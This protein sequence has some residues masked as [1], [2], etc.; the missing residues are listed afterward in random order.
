MQVYACGYKLSGEYTEFNIGKESELKGIKNSLVLVLIN[1]NANDKLL[2]YYSGIKTIIRN[3][4]KLVIVLDS[5]N[6]ST[7]RKTLCMLAVSMG[8]YNIYDCSMSDLTEDYVKS[9]L[10]RDASELEVEE[11]IGEDISA[12]DKAAELII[13]MQNY[14]RRGDGNALADLVTENKEVILSIPVVMDFL[15]KVYDTHVYGTDIKIS[16]MQQSL[17]VAMK[18]LEDTKTKSKEHMIKVKAQEEELNNLKIESE[19]IKNDLNAANRRNKD[20][21]K[22]ITELTDSEF[23]SEN[24]GILTYTALD[25]AQIRAMNKYIIYFKEISNVMYTLSMLKCLAKYIELSQRR[26]KLVIYDRPNDYMAI[27]KDMTIVNGEKFA[28]NPEILRSSKNIIMVTD[29]NMAVLKTILQ[30]DA[31]VIILFDRLKCR[32]DLVEGALVTKFYMMGSREKLKDLESS[33]GKSFPRDR[34]FVDGDSN[35]TLYIPMMSDYSRQMEIA[36]VSKYASTTITLGNTK[37]VLFQHILDC[38]GINLE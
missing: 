3:N 12:Y 9:L 10:E 20:L 29:T 33:T 34:T 25:T 13:Q 4:N 19:T 35:D 2:E 28:K 14:V 30:L 17:E 15:K 22:Q 38:C 21:E 23:G 7:I 31:D 36:R 8:C 16:K 32:E 27:Y 6:K 26:V 5:D 37:Q 1:S 11:Y 18:E 24:S